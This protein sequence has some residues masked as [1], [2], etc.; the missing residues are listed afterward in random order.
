MIKRTELLYVK[1]FVY[2]MAD[3]KPVSA[4]TVEHLEAMARF[5]SCT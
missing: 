2:M 3:S 4:T 5:C 1:E